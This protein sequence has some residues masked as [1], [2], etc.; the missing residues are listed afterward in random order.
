MVIGI[1]FLQ[2][3]VIRATMYFTVLLWICLHTCL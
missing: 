2:W 3:V 1:A